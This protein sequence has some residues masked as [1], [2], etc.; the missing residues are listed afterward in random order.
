MKKNTLTPYA[1]I[2][3]K[4]IGYVVLFCYFG[5]VINPEWAASKKMLSSPLY[6]YW[7]DPFSPP[8]RVWLTTLPIV[9]LVL[10]MIGLWGIIGFIS[11]KEKKVLP[12]ST[13]KSF[14][15]FSGLGLLWFV[16]AFALG[17][18]TRYIYDHQKFDPKIW[19]NPQSTSYVPYQLTLRQRMADDLTENV[20]PE[21]NLAEIETLLGT[22][23]ETT[24]RWSQWAWMCRNLGDPDLVYYVGPDRAGTMFGES[25]LIWFDES[26][27][28]ECARLDVPG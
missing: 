2:T 10:I 27:K 9:L 3:L 23:Q 5:F 20:L 11:K 15:I 4:R 25:L 21:S 8:F 6:F 26:G 17:L 28:F 1:G 14:V 24:G 19:Q 13:Y 16:C 18:G 12:N 22:S 7:H